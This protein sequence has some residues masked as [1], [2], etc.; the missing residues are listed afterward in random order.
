[1]TTAAPVDLQARAS[2]LVGALADA[3]TKLADLTSQGDRAAT[4]RHEAL[5]AADFA[6]AEGHGQT[7]AQLEAELQGAQTTVDALVAAQLAVGEQIRLRQHQSRR[8]E[9]ADL[10]DAGRAEAQTLL[11][12]GKT[13]LAEAQVKISRAVQVE[14]NA[15]AQLAPELHGLRV[16]LGEIPQMLLVHPRP[17]AAAIDQDTLLSAIVR[18]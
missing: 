9:L 16:A 11:A 8:D 13:A 18:R 5:T 14:E 12:E 1:M 15:A 3:Q 2:A 17:I 10:I 7:I 4:F 6:T